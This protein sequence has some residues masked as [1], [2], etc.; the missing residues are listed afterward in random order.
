METPGQPQPCTLEVPRRGEGWISLD[1][2]APS[3]GG[4]VAA[5]KVNRRQRPSGTWTDAGMAI[6]SEITLS[7]QERGRELEYRIIPVNKAGEGEPS[8]TVMAV[9]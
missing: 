2:K 3:D 5:F 9:L 1:W 4:R 7:D 6:E 8:N